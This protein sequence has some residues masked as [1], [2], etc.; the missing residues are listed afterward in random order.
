MAVTIIGLD[1]IQ[2]DIDTGIAD[3]IRREREA[4]RLADYRER[5]AR[6]AKGKAR[7]AE[8]VASQKPEPAFVD[9]TAYWDAIEADASEHGHV[10]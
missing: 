1:R 2:A 10:V 7:H 8:I 6:I 5:E 4:A 3:L 9:R